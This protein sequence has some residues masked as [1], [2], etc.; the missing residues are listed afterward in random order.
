[1]RALV[2]K[3]RR[4]KRRADREAPSIAM[5]LLR[6]VTVTLLVFHISEA[7]SYQYHSGMNSRASAPHPT[8]SRRRQRLAAQLLPPCDRGRQQQGKCG[9]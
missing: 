7:N 1:M 5:V 8:L 3:E 9:K 6:R 4:P 2:A